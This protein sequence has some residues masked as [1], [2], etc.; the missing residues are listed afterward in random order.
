MNPRYPFG[1]ARLPIVYLRPLGHLSNR[2]NHLL[3]SFGAGGIR[4]PVFG[5]LPHT[6][7]PG[8]LLNWHPYQFTDSSLRIR[9]A[10][11]GRKNPSNPPCSS[12]HSEQGDSPS[13]CPCSSLPSEQGGFEPP[14]PLRVQW[15]S[16]PSPSTARTPLQT[17]GKTLYIV[18][19]FCVK[20]SRRLTPR[21]I[22]SQ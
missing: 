7:R 20:A 2:I 15:F 9:L 21:S 3:I 8:F 12:L 14:E 11:I 5:I 10:R 4:L 16:K 1:Y 19:A 17:M 13:P 18:K 22:H 6:Y